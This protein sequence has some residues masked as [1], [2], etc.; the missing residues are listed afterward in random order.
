MPTTWCNVNFGDIPEVEERAYLGLEEN[1]C[2]RPFYKLLENL[3]IPS[4][5]AAA[6]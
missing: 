2:S 5:D 1:V 4:P 6:A 3:P